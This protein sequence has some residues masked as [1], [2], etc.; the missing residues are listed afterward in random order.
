M[1]GQTMTSLIE[2][3]HYPRFGP[4]MMWERCELL[5]AVCGSRILRGVKVE[6]IRHRNGRIQCVSG[7]T[8]TGEQV[9]YEGTHFISTMPLRELILALDPLPPEEVVRAAQRLRYRDYLTVVLVVDRES[10]FPDNWLYIHSPEV[11]LGRIQNYKNWSPEMT[12]DP[13]RTSLGLEYFL[14]DKDEEWHWSQ[15]R[16]LDLGMRECAQL[17]LITPD[18]V[19]DGTVVRMPKAYPVYDQQYHASITTLRHY[20][21]GFANL[22]TIGRN[23]LHR[24][25]NQD[26]S[27]L[28]GVYAARNIVGEKHD[29]WSVNTE[30]AY[31]EAG[32]V[33]HEVKGSRLVP[34]RVT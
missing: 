10:V 2:Q 15:E 26:H 20:L 17:G 1:D 31:H 9:D 33:A 22:Q 14:W 34:S 4:G 16:L 23:R 13:S 19:E 18:E 3:F 5:V 11:K 6:R 21:D 27:M 25:N 28:T 29:V 32:Q 12:P 8:P 24:Y 7:R 30:Q